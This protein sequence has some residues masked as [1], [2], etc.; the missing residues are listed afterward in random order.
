MDCPDADEL[1]ALLAHAL[2]AERRAAIVDHAAG[3]PACH[4]VITELAGG[5]ATAA[6]GPQGADSTEDAPHDAGA[7]VRRTVAA[8]LAGEH[9]TRIGRYHL[10]EL[11]G[12]GGMG[13]VWGAWDPELA[14]RVAL[15]LV[16]PRLPAAR[17]RILA[18][19]QALGKLSHPNVVPIYDVGIVD[20]QVYLVME[21]VQGTT[22]RAYASSPCSRRD[23]IDAYRQAGEG[24]AAAHRA[25]LV[26]RDFKPDNAIRGD[27]GRV[28]V[29]DFGLAR[30]DDDQPEHGL[31]LAGTP[32]YMPPE[33]ATGGPVAPAADQY[34]FAISLREALSRPPG[35]ASPTGRPAELPGWIA[36][37]VARG[38]APAPGDRFASM[39]ELLRALGRDPARVWSRRAVA[40]VAVAGVA[41][42]FAIGR[43]HDA[44]PTCTG[45]TAEIARSWSPASRAAM[46]GHLRTLGAFGAGEAD[47]LGDEL[48]RYT[49][50][51]AGEHR[52]ACLAHERGELPAALHERRIACLARGRAALA[53]TAELM[54]T[55]PA[56]GLAQA[57]VAVRSL[58]SVAGC[59]AADTS[60]VP[61]PPDAVAAQVAAAAPAVER[62]RVLAFAAR[63]DAAAVA[64]A[65]VAAAER[66]GYPPLVAR[67]QLALGWA[68]AALDQGEPATRASLER[69][70]DLA[71]RGS[72][73]VLAVEA[74]ARLIWAVSRY[75]GDVVGNWSVMEALAARTG[76]PG[77]FGRTLLY[78]NKAAARLAESDRAGARALLQQALAAS[79]MSAI[80]DGELEL[81]SV[82]QSLA[83][84][85]DDP[86][87]REARARQV[88]ARFEAVLGPNHPSTLEAQV[89][90]AMLIRNP[91]DAAA[92]YQAACDGYQRWHPDRVRPLADCAFERGWLADERGD[93]ALARAAMA[94]AAADPLSPHERSM[95]TIARGYLAI[96]GDGDAP[97]AANQLQQ[98][99]AA[100]SRAPEWWGRGAAAQAYVAAAIGW[101][102]LGRADD[103]ERCWAAAL[104]LLEGLHQPMYD[105]A[106]A[107]VRTSLARRWAEVRP[108]DARRVAREA[109]AWYRA[110]GG[111]DPEVAELTRITMPAGA[112]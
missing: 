18:E 98:L 2:D 105:R 80:A 92:Q 77:R 13:V 112:R 96:T 26:H 61:P 95:G 104:A 33:Q 70:V 100:G 37:I 28:R 30:S 35:D 66:T 93:V 44:A 60:G 20:D 72:D 47:R 41:A 83:V 23:L 22:L 27:D 31:R 56:D 68:Q 25:G 65:S 76:A 57:L 16:H 84:T 9:R 75:R 24:L 12:A 19:G 58:P 8:A 87:E 32:R 4:A 79:P 40:V 110:A 14:R 86:V 53:A 15:K 21:W 55:V 10:L 11:V 59:A 91:I 49:A 5:H 99:G 39:A 73:D 36:A 6:T 43:A 111:Y 89:V 64:G 62:A 94:L 102:R 106:L 101:Q 67:A 103:A 50:A 38:T 42:A 82:L 45:S 71:L 51:W 7:A 107:R 52:H 1:A 48:D 29:L 34:A 54:T 81:V 109:L 78:N 74:Y 17:D 46:A 97:A 63:P 85:A 69:A 108:E 90:A 88:V 3:C